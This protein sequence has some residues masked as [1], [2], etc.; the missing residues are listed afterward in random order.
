MLMAACM[1]QMAAIRIDEAIIIGKII[2]RRIRS[3]PSGTTEEEE[4]Y[5]FFAW[6]NFFRVPEYK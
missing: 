2:A 5:H 4:P 1:V 3:Y 6:V